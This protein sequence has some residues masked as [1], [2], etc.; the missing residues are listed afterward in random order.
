MGKAIVATDTPAM[1]SYITH[2]VNG[3]LVKEGDADEMHD[4]LARVLGDR[5]LRNR[6]GSAARAYAEVHLDADACTK[7]LADYFTT[8]MGS[9]R[10]KRES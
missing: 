8:L 6:L 7:V 5:E 2:G 10:T 4:A 1:R 3:L 9:S